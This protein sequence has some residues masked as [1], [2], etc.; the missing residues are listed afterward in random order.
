MALLDD[1]AKLPGSHVLDQLASGGASGCLF[2]LGATR[3][4]GVLPTSSSK[5]ESFP[6]K[7]YRILGEAELHAQARVVSFTPDGRSF[8]I[9]DPDVFMKDSC[10][11]YFKQTHYSLFVRQLN[12]YG[13]EWLAHGPD[14]GGFCRPC[15]LRGRPEFLDHIH[16][17]VIVPRKKR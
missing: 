13:F 3:S 6:S 14:R 16:R 9:H 10:P 1:H 2:Q 15:F 17:Q 12:F 4:F 8:K 7:V 5:P 11:K